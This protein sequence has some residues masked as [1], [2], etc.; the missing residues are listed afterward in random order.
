M[1]F[2]KLEFSKNWTNPDDFPTF[3]PNEAQVRADAQL[4]HDETKTY[5]NE[6]L[7]PAI[8]AL[9]ATASYV[10]VVTLTADG[11]D[12]EQRIQNAVVGGIVADEKS[13]TIQ[14]IPASTSLTDYTRSNIRGIQQGAD[15][16]VFVCDKIP[17]VNVTLYAVVTEVAV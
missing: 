15:T 8:S 9:G 12:A 7:L 1:A 2:E 5:I 10:T 3:E 4:L 13:Q 14:L 16:V 11:W 6:Y 17:E